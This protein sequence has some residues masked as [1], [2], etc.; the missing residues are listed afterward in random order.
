MRNKI[1]DIIKSTLNARKTDYLQEFDIQID[2]V[3]QLRKNFTEDKVFIE[4]PILDK[5]NTLGYIDIVVELGGCFYPIELKYKTTH[6]EININHFGNIQKY[7]LKKHSAYNINCYSFWSDVA[8]MEKLAISNAKVQQGIAVFV[9][10]DSRYFKGPENP[11]VDYAEFSIK[12]ERLIKEG[13][14]MAFK[15][16]DNSKKPFLIIS[17]SYKIYWTKMESLEGF[18][19]FIY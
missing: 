12:N 17:N 9:T 14:K 4:Y 2:L 19:F 11:S 7:K 15:T 13:E 16:K 10:N 8:R 1:I 6:K 5:N 3:N 18:K